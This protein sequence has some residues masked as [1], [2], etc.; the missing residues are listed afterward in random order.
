MKS[1][2]QFLIEND[3]PV[4]ITFSKWKPDTTRF[5]DEKNTEVILVRLIAND[6]VLGWAEFYKDWGTVEKVFVEPKW[7]RKGV[8]TKL[9]NAIEKKYNIRLEPSDNLEPSGL[10]FWKNRDPENKKVRYG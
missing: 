6:K 7:R 8:A 9:Y 4:K 2:K 3:I 1:F 10:Q 5:P